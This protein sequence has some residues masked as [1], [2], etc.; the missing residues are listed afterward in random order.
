MTA[1]FEDLH[2]ELSV[3]RKRIDEFAPDT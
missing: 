1:R 2:S 3:L